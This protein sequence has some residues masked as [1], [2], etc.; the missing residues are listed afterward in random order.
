M[1][2]ESDNF[3]NEVL[4]YAK[5]LAARHHEFMRAKELCKKKGRPIHST[6]RNIGKYWH[7]E[8]LIAK[9]GA[10]V[11]REDFTPDISHILGIEGKKQRRNAFRRAFGIVKGNHNRVRKEKMQNEWQRRL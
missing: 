1:L 8:M 7:L 2:K 6:Y 11:L 4:N 5:E 9:Y 3:K 10:I